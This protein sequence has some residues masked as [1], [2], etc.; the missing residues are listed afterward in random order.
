MSNMKTLT[1]NNQTT[2]ESW[3]FDVVDGGLRSAI[4]GTSISISVSASAW[5]Q[6]ED[7]THYTQVVKV[8]GT[9][10]NS[11]IDLEPSPEQVIE[12]MNN[13]SSLFAA[14]ENGV[15]TLYAIPNAP[16][17]NMTI[18]ATMRDLPL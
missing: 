14:N 7:G 16:T 9:T 8:S 6:S 5:V 3:T 2:G 18:A 17:S 11:K 15:I 12:L 10:A 1:I 4:A 13:E